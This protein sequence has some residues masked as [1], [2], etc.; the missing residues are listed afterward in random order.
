MSTYEYSLFTYQVFGYNKWQIIIYEF[1]QQWIAM[2]YN[3]FEQKYYLIHVQSLLISFCCIGNFYYL[4]V[5]KPGLD[6]PLLEQMGQ[7]DYVSEFT[8]TRRTL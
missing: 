1:Q 7:A 4:H 2:V 3:G 8:F 5:K 6:K